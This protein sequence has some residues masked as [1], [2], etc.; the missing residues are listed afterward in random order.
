MTDP[1]RH[2]QIEAS[3]TTNA[4]AWAHVVRD[5]LIPS[6]RAGTDDAIVAACLA[7]GG[8]PVLD[9]GC[10]EGWLVRALHAR[11]VT[12]AGV[13]VSAP[14]IERARER[15]GGRFDVV[16]Y[17]ALEGDATLHAGPWPLIVCNFALLG[18][19]VHPLLAALRSRLAPR[20]RVLVQTVH[21][22]SAR[23]EG[24]YRSEWRTEAF[25][26]FAVPFPTPMPWY[27]RTLG[28]WVAQFALAGLRI[29]QLDEPLHP[30]T[31]APL[32]LLFHCEA[33]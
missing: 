3:W 1:L 28:S 26:G 32:S 20:G 19:P 24:P 5:G 12:A 33:A 8:S 27:Y 25:D 4:D 14:L 15:G 31:G 17:A 2:A 29:V 30:M 21:S 18:E 7:C 23:G 10:G 22:W 9:V 11:G 13:D 6:R 16:S